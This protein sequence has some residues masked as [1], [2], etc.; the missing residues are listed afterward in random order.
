MAK[1]IETLIEDIYA[2]FGSGIDF[3]QEIAKYFGD[4]MSKMVQDRVTRKQGDGHLRMSNVG[5]PC[6]RKLWY[7]CNK[8]YTEGEQLEKNVL[9]KFLYGDIIEELI[10]YLAAEAGHTVEGLQDE[11]VIE[12]IVGHRDAVID[13]VLIDVKSCST[14]TFSKFTNHLSPDNDPFGYLDQLQLYLWA[15]QSDPVVT[16]KD[17]AGFLAVDK[18]LGYLCLDLHPRTGKDYG[19]LINQKKQMISGETPPRGFDPEPDGQSG[20]MK[21][22]TYCGYCEWKKTCHPG[23]RAFAYAGSPRF[24]TEVVKT[25][26]NKHGPIREINL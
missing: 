16:N 21:L 5:T 15:S 10:L 23:L 26:T 7:T 22:G 12:G 1:Q 24:L 18:V 19:Y 11:L 20:N 3:D 9:M 4:Q 14:Q 2:L 25:P 13:G 6:E 8:P 17:V